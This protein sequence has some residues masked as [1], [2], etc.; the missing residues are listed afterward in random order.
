M[1]TY[2]PCRDDTIKETFLETDGDDAGFDRG[3]IP[4]I[5]FTLKKRT[6]DLMTDAE[7]VSYIKK[8]GNNG[9]YAPNGGASNVKLD[10]IEKTFVLFT[11]YAKGVSDQYISTGYRLES[12]A[13]KLPYNDIKNYSQVISNYVIGNPSFTL[14]VK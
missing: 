13:T 9:Y 6:S 5:E 14:Y 2:Q 8:G 11:Y 4:H 7:L 10:T 3:V 12:S 1:T